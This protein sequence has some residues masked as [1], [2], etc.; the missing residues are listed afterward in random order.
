MW[1]VFWENHEMFPDFIL[2]HSQ[3]AFKKSNSPKD[4]LFLQDFD[5]SQ[6]SR[7]AINAMYQ[8]GAKKFSIP[9]RR[10][11][12]NPI[13]NVFNYVRIKLHEESLKRNIT[14]ANFEEYSSRVKKTSLAVPVEYINKI[15]SMDNR[16]S[17]MVKKGGK[18][19]KY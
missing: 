13:E 19:I 17:M 10:P 3:E 8:V 2:K 11:D 5:P 16:L 4:E 15:E 12:M 1:A 6:N 9:A 7:K 14:F 18:R